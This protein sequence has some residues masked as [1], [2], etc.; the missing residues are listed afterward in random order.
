MSLRSDIKK[1]IDADGLVSPTPTFEGQRYASG[2]GVLYT[3]EYMLKLAFQPISEETLHNALEMPIM[4]DLTYGDAKVYT[5]TIRRCMDVPGLLNR[6]PGHP[7]QEGPDD[8]VGLGA[9]LAV[10]GTTEAR[11]I[12]K[13]VLAY[14]RKHLGYFK[15]SPRL[16]RF[17]LKPL[18]WRQVQLITHFKYAAGEVPNAFLR[19]I[20]SVVVALG[21]KN[22]PA[23]DSDSF[24]LTDLL[25]M[26]RLLSAIPLSWYEKKAIELFNKRVVEVHGDKGLNGAY[27]AHFGEHPLSRY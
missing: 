12:A 21:G 18:I 27:A 4:G 16:P 9:G 20:W 19:I 13:D 7:D 22:K 1:Y 24:I 14:G 10:C 5:D 26:T 6:A 8:Y 25:I 11:N 17:S 15:N 23:H 3:S 2:N